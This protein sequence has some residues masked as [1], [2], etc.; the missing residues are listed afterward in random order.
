[1]LR[2]IRKALHLLN[3]DGMYRWILI[4]LVA[5]VA[6]AFEMIGAF[7][8]FLVVGLA[9][10]P[11]DQIDIPMIGNIRNLAPGLSGQSFLLWTLAAIAALFA[12]RGAVQIGATYLQARVAHNAG[13]RIS[14]VIV[15]GYLRSPYSLFL[16]KDSAELIRNGHQ[17]VIAVVNS[18]P[19]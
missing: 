2:T 16:N 13:A 1:V 12:V 15:E 11:A 8:V 3:R 18:S 5:M 6:A 19:H 14:R 9:T 4:L 10:S 7:L 17:A